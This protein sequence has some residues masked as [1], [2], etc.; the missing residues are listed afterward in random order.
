MLASVTKIHH[1]DEHILGSL[2]IGLPPLRRFVLLG[3]T[4]LSACGAADYG[5]ASASGDDG[6]VSVTVSGPM[7][8]YL[9]GRTALSMGDAESAANLLLQ[10]LKMDP[11]NP[12]LQ[13]AAFM[14]AVRAGRPE[15]TALAR[16]VPGG[17]TPQLLLANAD[18]KAG[19]WASA[20]RRFAGVARNGP[21]LIVQPIMV[22]WSQ[23]GDGRIDAALA[24]LQPLVDNNRLRGLYALHAGLISDLGERAGQADRFYRIADSATGTASAEQARMLAS[25]YARTGKMAE[26]QR[27]F[28]PF[29]DNSGS[30]SIVIPNLLRNAAQIQV[31]SP[32]DGLAEAYFTLAGAVRA[33]EGNDLSE[34][35]LKLALDLR[36]DLTLA[37]LLGAE[38]LD[39]D[40]HAD[41]ALAQLDPVRSSDPLYPLVA[42]RQAS[43]LAKTGKTDKALQI[44][45]D[46]QRDYPDRPEPYVLRAD[47]LRDAKRFP[48]AIDAYTAAIAHSATLQS[49]LW[50]LYYQRG[51]SFDQAKQPDKAEAD[52]L[53]AL[54]L[55]PD[56][57]F[58][59]NYLGYSWTEQGRNLDRAHKM[60]QR[61]VTLRPDDG[62]IVDSLG[63]LEL[64]QGNVKGSVQL[65]QR[66]VELEPAD[67]TLNGHLGDAYWAAGRKLEAQFQWRRALVFNPEPEDLPKLKAKLR[68]SEAAL[69]NEPTKPAT[70]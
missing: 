49:N 30:F 47:T 65:L 51:I 46:L 32:Q 44:L 38:L 39:D 25:W 1:A 62:A 20:E 13:G 7:G 53:R 37:R 21:L 66:A 22:A 36:P 17:V 57:P 50:A 8:A 2:M 54:E 23:Y 16:E 14:A 15:A 56:Q 67:P 40:G 45:T 55:A 34:L 4:M 9:A 69:G 63:W 29:E 61:A 31:R 12:E 60:I 11:D 26:A 10:G 33:Q 70:P 3:L 19:R 27:V 42:L 68:D 43:L 18:V 28:R 5:R 41:L 64:K 52:L 58:V 35:L 24:T 6:P 59:L 48:E